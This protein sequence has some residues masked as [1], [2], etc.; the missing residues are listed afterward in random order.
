MAAHERPTQQKRDPD[1]KRGARNKKPEPLLDRSHTTETGNLS[2]AATPFRPPVESNAESLANAQSGEERAAISA[3]L[4]QSYGNRYVQRLVESMRIQPKL[5]VNPPNDVYEQEADRVADG[6][7][8]AAAPKAAAAPEEEEVQTRLSRARPAAKAAA[9]PEEEEPLQ[10]KLS[11]ARSVPKSQAAPEEEEPLQ[12]KLSEA[13]PAPEGEG[14]EAEEEETGAV[15]AKRAGGPGAVSDDVETRINRARGQGHAPSEQTRRALEPRL[16]FDLGDV[17][18]HTDAEAGRLSQKLGAEAFTSKR[19]IFFKEGAYRPDSDS[20]KWLLAHELTHVAQQDATNRNPVQRQEEEGEG[21]STAEGTVNIPEGEETEGEEKGF[22]SPGKMATRSRALG[23]LRQTGGTDVVSLAK[24]PKAP[25]SSYK[26]KVGTITMDF[27]NPGNRPPADPLGAEIFSCSHK[28][29][30]V[31][32]DGSKANVDFALTV[33]CPWGTKPNGNI[34]VPSAASNVVTT[35]NYKRVARHLT[36][37]KANSWQPP[38][39]KYWSKALV[40]RHET[41]HSTDDWKWAQG[42]GKKVVSAYLQGKTI[43]ATTATNSTRTLLDKAMK[44]M[45]AANTE[46]YH[47]G[48]TSYLQYAGEKRAYADGK[49]PFQDLANA[50][51]KQGKKLEKEAKQ[52]AKML[53]EEAA[54]KKKK[55]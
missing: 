15:M 10:G 19:D 7:A 13:R 28:S 32:F 43:P 39:S 55:K 6:V 21:S 50:V 38:Q 22:T 18:L 40:E 17:K 9:A 8:R 44:E 4:Q 20:G 41:Y 45:S 42:P 53:A 51:T 2:F 25:P 27:K 5:T 37:V 16:G 23:K 30:K 34:D 35:A 36:P 29:A 1:P 14:E 46:F 49:T 24:K 3:D 48:G 12:G 31:T 11:E 26:F 47:G 54:K 33:K 52:K